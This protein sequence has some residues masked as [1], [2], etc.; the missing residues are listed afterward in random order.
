MVKIL[1]PPD[2]AVNCNLSDS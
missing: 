2:L 1:S